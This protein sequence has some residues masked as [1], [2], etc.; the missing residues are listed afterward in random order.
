MS[1][2]ADGAFPGGITFGLLKIVYRDI[3]GVDLV[4]ASASC[5]TLVMGMFPGVESAPILNSTLNPSQDT[6]IMTKAEGVAPMDT[7]SVTFF[8]I[9]VDQDP[10]IMYADDVTAMLEK[11]DQFED[12]GAPGSFI[13][14]SIIRPISSGDVKK[15]TYDATNRRW[16]LT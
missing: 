9:L 1:R 15:W 14:S 3:N 13:S 2:S 4:P 8:I 5:G 10:A 11:S 6:W 16:L 12:P 7:V